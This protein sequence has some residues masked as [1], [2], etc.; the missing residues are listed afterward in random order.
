[1]SILSPLHDKKCHFSDTKCIMSF[2]FLCTCRDDGCNKAQKTRHWF[3]RCARLWTTYWKFIK[4]LHMLNK[5]CLEK[6]KRFHIN[7]ALT[8]VV[9]MKIEKSIWFVSTVRCYAL[10]SFRFS[11][12][13]INS[14]CI[15]MCEIMHKWD[16]HS[17]SIFVLTVWRHL[18]QGA[19]AFTARQ[20]SSFFLLFS[21]QVLWEKIRNPLKFSFFENHRW[22]TWLRGFSNSLLRND[23]DDWLVAEVIV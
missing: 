10:L 21:L 22:H 4:H 6:I 16:G 15:L 14:R 2:Y 20:K 17:C 19:K 8:Q 9:E 5:N 11:L 13:I 18:L 12:P 1:M 7:S 23:M 3:A